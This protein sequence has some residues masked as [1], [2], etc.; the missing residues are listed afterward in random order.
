M[1]YPDSVTVTTFGDKEIYLLGT[2]HVSAKS[3]EEVTEMVKL[4]DPDSICVELCEAR[5]KSIRDRDSW[6]KMDIFKVLKEKK[7]PFLF[8][9][10]LMSSFYRKLGK[11][12]E[13]TPGAEMIQGVTESENSSAELVLADR[14]IE[15]TLRRVWG[16]LKFWQR[17][18]FAA[19]ILSSFFVKGE[20]IDTDTIEQ[21]KEKDHLEHAMDEFAESFP[22][23]R[24][25]LIDERD[26]YLTEKIKNAPGK[27]VLA[28]VGAAHVKGIVAH[29]EDDH[30]LDEINVIPKELPIIKII[31]WVIPLIVIALIA[32]GFTRSTEIGTASIIIWI[33]VNG[34]FSAIGAIIALGHPLTI[35]TAFIAAPI[36]SLN[37]T[38]GAGI[39]GGLAQ[40]FIKKPTVEDLENVPDAMESFKSFRSNSFTRVLLVFI[41]VS[42]GSFIGTWVGGFKILQK[43]AAPT[44]T[45]QMIEQLEELSNMEDLTN[46]N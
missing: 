30:D 3:V 34:I 19:S 46:E 38:I 9:Q 6:K 41:M 15:I 36:T 33:M 5:L 10:L 21:L 32:F 40:A 2:A 37:P 13:V 16:G 20:E 42:L 14:N 11:E 24:R 18:N 23:I 28:V 39:V 27:K 25:P 35:I 29:M 22:G 12:L 7:V 17:M 31:G 1:S 8:A 44:E 26:I 45:E 43:V 4:T